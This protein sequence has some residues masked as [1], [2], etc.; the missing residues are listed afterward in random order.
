MFGRISRGACRLTW[1]RVLVKS[2]E[3]SYKYSFSRPLVDYTGYVVVVVVVD[4]LLFLINIV[5]V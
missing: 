1:T 5:T 4:H 3:D 2:M